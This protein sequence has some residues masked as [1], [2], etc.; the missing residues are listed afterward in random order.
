MRNNFIWNKYSNLKNNKHQK[1]KN[2]QRHLVI[3]IPKKY[4]KTF[5]KTVKTAYTEK[6]KAR[7]KMIF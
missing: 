7:S 2:N 3:Q 1:A 6:I 4:I 5:W